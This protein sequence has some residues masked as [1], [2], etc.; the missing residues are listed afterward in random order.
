MGHMFDF[1]VRQC[2]RYT[3]LQQNQGNTRFDAYHIP[4]TNLRHDSVGLGLL[5][6]A[7]HI[8]SEMLYGWLDHSP[9]RVANLYH[10]HD[11]LEHPSQC[12]S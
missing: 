9:Y 4:H 3:R 8:S 7:L 11:H 2:R 1:K 10:S 5:S 6:R 12:H